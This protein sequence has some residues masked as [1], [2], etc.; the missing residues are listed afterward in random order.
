MSSWP[1]FNSHRFTC[2]ECISG[3]EWVETYLKDPVFQAEALLFLEESWCTD[4]HPLCVPTVQKHFI[5][6]HVMVMDKFMVPTDIC[7]NNYHACTPTN[8]PHS[9]LP[10]KTVKALRFELASPNSDHSFII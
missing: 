5:P 8:P 1:S 4:E 2:D 3:M 9:T 7:N 10:P 6:M